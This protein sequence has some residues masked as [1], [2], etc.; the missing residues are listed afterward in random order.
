MTELT[1]LQATFGV[2]YN[3]T[4]IGPHGEMKVIS[5]PAVQTITMDPAEI[6]NLPYPKKLNILSN[7]AEIK[8]QEVHDS[9]GY[10]LWPW[11]KKT[12]DGPPSDNDDDEDVRTE[13]VVEEAREQLTR[14]PVRFTGG[15]ADEDVDYADSAAHAVTPGLMAVVEFVSDTAET[16]YL[17]GSF[18]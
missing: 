4:L 15:D 5:S 10:G 8:L 7:A 9:E 6:S 13:D 17:G 2:R 1:D 14:K 16:P 3:L 12:P 18:W 11:E